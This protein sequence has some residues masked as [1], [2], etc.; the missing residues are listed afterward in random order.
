MYRTYIFYRACGCFLYAPSIFRTAK[1]GSGFIQE[2]DLCYAQISSLSSCTRMYNCSTAPRMAVVPRSSVFALQTRRY[3]MYTEVHFVPCL[4]LIFAR[5]L[6][7]RRLF[8]KAN[9]KY[10]FNNLLI[11]RS[12]FTRL[13]RLP[14]LCAKFYLKFCTNFFR[15]RT[16]TSDR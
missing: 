12:I 7:L 9:G 10:I 16:N 15:K 13:M 1:D 6:Y 11:L 8:Q 2:R 14:S 3:K 5:A 4:R